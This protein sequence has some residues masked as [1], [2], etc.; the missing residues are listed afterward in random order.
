MS[1]P[2]ILPTGA[3]ASGDYVIYM[4]DY[5][6]TAMDSV[7][8]SLKDYFGNSTIQDWSNQW[9]RT[10]NDIATIVTTLE[11]DVSKMKAQTQMV[12][13]AIDKL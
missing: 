3:M 7:T 11:D 8:S 13:D 10:S 5:I 9:T 6:N 1:L 12:D 2:P 4:L